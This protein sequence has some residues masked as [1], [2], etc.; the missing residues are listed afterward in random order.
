MRLQRGGGDESVGIETRCGRVGGRDEKSILSL[1]MPATNCPARD[2][3]LAVVW[4]SAREF[5]PSF[6]GDVNP[7]EG[8]RTDAR[9]YL[10]VQRLS[11]GTISRFKSFFSEQPKKQR[12]PR[13][14]TAFSWFDIRIDVVAVRRRFNPRYLRRVASERSSMSIFQSWGFWLC[15]PIRKFN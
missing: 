13:N 10:Y 3:I 8:R 2:K 11:A 4:N 9:E 7:F 5:L 15:V 1:E 14:W 6:D 12:E